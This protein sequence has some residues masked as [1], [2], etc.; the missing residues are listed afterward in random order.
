MSFINRVVAQSAEMGYLPTVYSSVSPDVRGR[1]YIG[2][3]GLMG[4]RCWPKKVQS[5]G[6]SHD[7]ADATRLW[8]VSEQL[9]GVSY[10]RSLAGR[11]L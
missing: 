2:P 4:Q 3:G 9:T 5:N 1:D 6:R 10:A 11:H 7:E 8:V